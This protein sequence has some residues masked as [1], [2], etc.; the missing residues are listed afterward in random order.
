MLR[1]LK[2]AVEFSGRAAEE[3]SVG[4]RS[5]SLGKWCEQIQK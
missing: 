5:K 2:R 3:G 1:H 4:G